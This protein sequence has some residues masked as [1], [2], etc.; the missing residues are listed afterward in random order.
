VIE[1]VLFRAYLLK[2]MLQIHGPNLAIILNSLLFLAAHVNLI[3]PMAWRAY[4]TVLGG[5]L[6][7]GIVF[8]RYGL[9]PAI[10]VHA[11]GNLGY[12]LTN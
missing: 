2:R 10:L 11:G 1:E 5:G 3:E 9:V 8:S 4:F 12:H 7:F 6:V